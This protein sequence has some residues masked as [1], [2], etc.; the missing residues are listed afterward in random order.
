M[1]ISHRKKFIYMKTVKT[2]G[3]SVESF[4]ERYCM[5][6]GEWVF[7]HGR[8]EYESD[9][10]VIGYRG[11]NPEGKKW[12]NHMSA[13]EIK[14]LIGNDIWTSYYKFCVIRNPYDK[15]LSA[16]FFFNN[17]KNDKDVIKKFREWALAGNGKNMP[18]DR[19]KYCIDN[20][21]CVNFFVHYEDLKDDIE[22][23]CNR[24][25]IVFNPDEI[26]RLK[27]D[28]RNTK[29]PIQ[30]FYNNEIKE[31]VKKGMHLNSNNLIISFL[32]SNK[33]Y[34]YAYYLY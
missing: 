19:N 18:I 8:E 13:I 3:T 32:F 23:V 16:Y 34:N 4:F 17:N 22:K 14:N 11:S 20:E 6:E 29:I 15:V 9:S 21:I 10:G 25:D 33:D 26:P 5:P 2:A 12:R 1:L 31:L 30:D 27:N 28:T 7:S 24:L